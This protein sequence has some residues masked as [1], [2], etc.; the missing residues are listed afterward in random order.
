MYQSRRA[1]PTLSKTQGEL[2]FDMITRRQP[3]NLGSFSR[4]D[5]F[6]RLKSAYPHLPWSKISRPCWRVNRCRGSLLRPEP[7]SHNL[8]DIE[9]HCF[10]L[11]ARIQPSPSPRGGNSWTGSLEGNQKDRESFSQLDNGFHLV[12][13]LSCHTHILPEAKSHDLARVSTGVES[14]CFALSLSLIT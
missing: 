2:F 10:A 8:T 4:L 11:G 6:F 7:E 12:A 3:K 5:D 14:H 1:H 9:P 13:A